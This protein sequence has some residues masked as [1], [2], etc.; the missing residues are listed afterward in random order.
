[1]IGLLCVCI[2]SSPAIDN[3]YS[4][5]DV[6]N[7]ES[8]NSTSTAEVEHSIQMPRT[9]EEVMKDVIVYVEVRSGA[10]NRTNG[11]KSAIA[12]LGTKVNDKLLR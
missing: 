6:I 2:I 10:E 1:M 9:I 4:N 3:Y 7:D 12:N 8:S 11:I 5:F